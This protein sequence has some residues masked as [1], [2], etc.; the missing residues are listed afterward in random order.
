[1]KSF[2]LG[3]IITEANHK[4]LSTATDYSGLNLRSERLTAREPCRK[5]QVHDREKVA[6]S[7]CKHCDQIMRER[8]I[9]EE[10]ADALADCIAG[11]LGID[12]GEHSSCNEPWQNAIDAAEY[13][14]DKRKRATLIEEKAL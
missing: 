11:L 14:L 3:T 12:I 8:D 5:K 10:Q 7:E 1:V 13:E 9:A 4:G 2:Q 6:M